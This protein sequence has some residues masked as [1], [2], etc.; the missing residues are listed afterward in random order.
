MVYDMLVVN[1][2]KDKGGTEKVAYRTVGAAFEAKNGGL[3]CEPFGGIAITGPF[4]I[5]PRKEKAGD[6]QAG[7]AEEAF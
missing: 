5:R 7:D 4:I 2:W 1:K 3:N 6:E